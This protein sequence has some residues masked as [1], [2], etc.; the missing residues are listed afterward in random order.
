MKFRVTALMIAILAALHVS[1]FAVDIEEP[2]AQPVTTE[3]AGIE[4]GG[5]YSG[6]IKNEKSPY[7]VKETLVVP[8]GRSLLIEPGVILKFAEGTG[9]EV[10]GG[11][12]AIMGE[13]DNPVLFTSVD[14]SKSWNGVSITGVKRSEVQF[15][16]VVNAEYGFAVESGALELRDVTIDHSKFAALYVRNGAADVQWCKI[17]NGENVGVWSTQSADVN[18]DGSSLSGNR[19]AVVV[20]EGSNLQLQRSKLL[21]NDVAVLDL[22][23]NHLSQRN[24]LIEDNRVGI[25]SRDLPSD[26]M[27][28]ALNRNAMD[29]QQDVRSLTE[30][31]GDEPRNSYADGTKLHA[32][33]KS[34]NEETPWQLSGNVGLELGYHKVFTRHNSSGEDFVFGRDTVSAGERYINY[35]QTPGF[36]ANWNA[37]MM[38]ESPSGQTFE[39]T[40]DISNDTWDHFK[41]HYLQ[42]QYSDK[43]QTLTLGDFALN[44]GD[45]Y[46]EGL[47]VF[48]GMYELNLFQN[49]AKEPLFVGTAFAGESRAPKIVG[50]RNYDVYNEYVEDGEAEAQRIV[51]GT[52]VRWNMHR[53]FNGTLGF[54]G[55]KDY[56]ENPFLRDGQS[57]KVNTASP[58]V[59]SRNLFADGNWLFFPGD[60]KLNG[61]IAIGAA[62]T[63]NAARIRAINRVFTE[64]GLDAS[65]FGLL[66]QLMK[67]PRKVNSLSNEQLESI[68]GDSNFL[69]P[70]EMRSELRRLLEK[71]ADESLKTEVASIKPSDADFWDHHH[72]AVAGS[73]EWSSKNTFIEGF[74]RYVGS[75]YY[76]AG[77][78]DLLQNTRLLG[79][80]L[81]HRIFDFWL[82]SFGYTMN[83]EN[84][85][86]EGSNYNIFGMGEGTRWGFFSGADDGWLKAHEQDENRTLYIHDGYIGTDFKINDRVSIAFKY[87]LNYRTR[88]TPQRLYAN[89]AASSGIYKDEWFAARKGYSSFEIID[90]DDTLK[91]DSARWAKYYSLS[92][93]EY[94]ATQFEE[95]LMK[96]TVQLGLTFKLPMNVLKVGAILSVR[97]DFSKFMQDDLLNGFNFSNET[98]GILGYY[99]HGKD[100][101]EQRYPVSLATTVGD[102][103]NTFSITPRY[104]IFNRY[105]MTE[106]E[107]TMTENVSFPLMERFLE[108]SLN[109]NLRQNFLDYEVNDDKVSEMELDVDGA[110]SLRVNHTDQLYSEWTLGA[111]FDYRPDNKADAYKDLYLT[112]SINY[113]F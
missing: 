29:F 61:Q 76:S 30:T 9:I 23:D 100:F 48:G 22:G 57:E 64:A 13:M 11:S 52:R 102:F 5:I 1:A 51:A 69:T 65:N 43:I 19:I 31:L 66:N 32:L 49:V 106:F 33:R 81:R 112:A 39:F 14:A 7:L 92:D 67:N 62:D 87:L 104:K 41:V 63:L 72:L 107:W 54:I 56:L 47:N 99:F 2:I 71:A 34:S 60:I 35:F 105:D 74:F 10:R 90:G 70:S 45:I 36:F 78:S 53:R 12:I 24:S 85:A 103:R 16:Q 17:R 55:S 59:V 8:E 42:A 28:R 4:L 98:Y 26:D 80:N 108:L 15:L 88:S 73:Y 27:K 95:K 110:V 94:L 68:F 111:I 38:L 21:D 84:A 46:L 79:G 113:S 75:E 40:S 44:A 18:L 77:S 96:H 37:H 91:I 58:L 89:Y 86:G 82:F 25:V 3:L 83:V 20:T 97:N 6:V 109:G 50:K 93:K 101:F